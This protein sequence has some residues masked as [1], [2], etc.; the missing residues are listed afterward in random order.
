MDKKYLWQYL[1]PTGFRK[2]LPFGKSTTNKNNEWQI[3]YIVCC[4]LHDKIKWRECWNTRYENSLCRSLIHYHT[5]LLPIHDLKKRGA[6]H[7]FI[8]QEDVVSLRLGFR[9]NFLSVI[10]Y[11]QFFILIS[12]QALSRVF[13]KFKVGPPTCPWSDTIRLCQ[14]IHRNALWVKFQISRIPL[15]GL[16]MRLGWRYRQKISSKS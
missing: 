5:L 10:L 7:F 14:N 3:D 9:R 12:F 6:C 11:L 4:P 15:I 8:L 1:L 2:S 16:E 13:W